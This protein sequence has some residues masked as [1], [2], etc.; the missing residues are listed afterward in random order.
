MEAPRA[1]QGPAGEN[2]QGNYGNLYIYKQN[3]YDHGNVKNRKF[4][5][6]SVFFESCEYEQR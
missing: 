1:L 2:I 5:K 4:M 3:I 6:L